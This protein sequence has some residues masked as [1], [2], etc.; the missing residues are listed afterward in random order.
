MSSNGEPL[1][2]SAATAAVA[3]APAA[4]GDGGEAGPDGQEPAATEAAATAEYVYDLDR[5]LPVP[6]PVLTRLIGGKAAN[7]MVM[8]T[9]LGLPVPPG[10]TIT[11]VACNAYLAGGW[12]AG[13]DDELQAHLDR[14]AGQI[15]RRFGDPAGPLLVS[16]RSGAPVSMPGMMD[17]ILDLGLNDATA[18]GLARLTKDADFAA[19]CLRRFR[20]MYRDIVG[21]APPDDPVQQLRGAVEAVFRSWNS[22][23]AQAYRAHEGIPGNLG[24]GVTVQA[25]VFGN[26][27]ADSGTGVLFT[28]SPATGQRALY[29]D[30]MF[31][32]QGEDVVAGTHKPQPLSIL[33]ERLP[34]V[35]AELRRDADL[36]E[37]HFADLCDI[38]FTIEQGKLWLLQ[39]RIGKR[40][41]RA[42]LRI[43]VDMAE[44]PTF[45]CSR[46]EAV[47]RTA[48]YLADPPFVFVRRPGGPGVLTTGLPASPGVATGEIATTPE[49]A[50]SA[51]AAG[52]PVILVRQETS[53]S[54]VRGMAHAAGILT[55]RGGLASHAAVV[56]RGWGIPAVVGA[57]AV[58]LAGA[59]LTIA[60]REFSAGEHISIDGSTGEVYAGDVAGT[61]EIA[62]EA[63]T[64]LAWAKELG[65]EIG[66]PEG[67]GAAAAEGEGAAAEGEG[68]AAAG[69]VSRDDLLQALLIK[70]TA[71]AE[72]LAVALS[73]DPG[74]VSALAAGL[75]ADGLAE[76]RAE[77]CRLT[78]AGRLAALA[79]FAADRERLGT[80][81]AVAYLEAFGS[82]DRRMKDTV[83]AWQVR[84]S[85]DEPIFNDHTDP[86]Y[87][88]QV[89]GTL[90]ELHADTVAWMAPLAGAFPRFGRYRA[91]LE[92]ALAAACDG[93]QRYVTSPRVDSYHSVWFELHEDLIRLAN[94]QRA[95]EAAGPEGLS[96]AAQRDGEV[97]PGLGSGRQAIRGSSGSA[98]LSASA[99]RQ[100]PIPYAASSAR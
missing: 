76:T 81:Q 35:G 87:D 11:T 83:T 16:V 56:A 93:D 77:G 47:R 43:A 36:L 86:A 57:S 9:E 15:G 3:P 60:G 21:S 88:A 71:P 14:M 38:E 5:P 25:M 51:D 18:G 39:V 2:G 58:Q 4:A 68:A 1:A 50:E 90:A 24:T 61:R 54:D 84:S 82:L 98:S 22:D 20:Q 66:P 23:R 32:A 10:F 46:E 45:P 34:A 40:S 65:I 75:V 74:L 19:D 73:C 29:G 63:A 8:A 41:P 70:G 17:T 27:G 79:I 89:L 7:L 72:Q 80:D 31:H 59:E 91:R 96:A 62:P 52:R 64:L 94:R 12:P 33:D 37:R 78:G 26:R 69:P 100:T 95:D 28:R 53:P 97:T 42:A 99:P 92:H 44:D 30:V 49:A 6:L 67:E 13:L 55:A 85:G 48:R